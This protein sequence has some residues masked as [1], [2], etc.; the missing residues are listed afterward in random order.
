MVADKWQGEQNSAGVST[1]E[2]H[3]EVL[4]LVEV[5]T[6]CNHPL[7]FIVTVTA[8]CQPSFHLQVTWSCLLWVFPWGREVKVWTSHRQDSLLEMEGEHVA[9][10]KAPQLF[11]ALFCF[12]WLFVFYVKEQNHRKLSQIVVWTCCIARSASCFYYETQKAG[13]GVPSSRTE[14]VLLPIPA[15]CRAWCCDA[16]VGTQG[17]SSSLLPKDVESRS[18]GCFRK[19]LGN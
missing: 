10:W 2:V 9:S 3:E 8:F 11:S 19:G 7:K 4:F 16:G 18:T 15:G 13:L 1:K 14:L 5:C 17:D 12:C 6:S